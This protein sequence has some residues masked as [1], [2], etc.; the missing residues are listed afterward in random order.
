M[1]GVPERRGCVPLSKYPHPLPES[2]SHPMETLGPFVY[3]RVR[4][5]LT[6]L[7]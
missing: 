5:A 1:Y 6:G 2:H 4:S 3:T 7:S